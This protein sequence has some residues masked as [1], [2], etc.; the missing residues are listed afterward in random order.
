MHFS[1]FYYR[2]QDTKSYPIVTLRKYWAMDTISSQNFTPHPTVY[3]LMESTTSHVSINK[4][5]LLKLLK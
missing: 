4:L 3:F 2:F 1:L 5:K